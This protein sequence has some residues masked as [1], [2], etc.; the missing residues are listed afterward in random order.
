M[1]SSP[2]F[3]AR[4]PF[5]QAARMSPPC[6]SPI[7]SLS[8]EVD[9]AVEMERVSSSDLDAEKAHATE[10]A[11]RLSELADPDAGK[12]PEERAAIVGPQADEESRPVAYS[13]A[14]LALPPVLPR[15]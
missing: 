2:C 7:M 6:F 9:T 4:Y 15:S 8:K 12:S 10:H 14:V 1:G 5:Q 11:E 13:M 3:C